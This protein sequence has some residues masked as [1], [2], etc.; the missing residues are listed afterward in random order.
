MEDPEV[1]M[2]SAIV[3]DNRV[4]SAR[5]VKR[6]NAQVDRRWK[7]QVGIRCLLLDGAQRLAVKKNRCWSRRRKATRG[8]RHRKKQDLLDQENRE[9]A[10]F[11]K[12]KKEE[13]EEEESLTKELCD[14]LKYVKSGR[15][16]H[17]S[18][19]HSAPTSF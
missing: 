11:Q 6:Y 1:D 3:V 12:G 7:R 10:V 16:E 9:T 13:E 17:G 18:F 5:T 14:E 8:S 2:F 4:K 15:L 19:Q